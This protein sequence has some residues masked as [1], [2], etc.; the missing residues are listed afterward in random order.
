MYQN[1]INPPRSNMKELTYA[2][3]PF[4]PN[5]YIDYSPL[6]KVEVD[7]VTVEPSRHSWNNKIKIEGTLVHKGFSEMIPGIFFKSV[8]PENPF[9]IDR[10]ELSGPCTIVFFIDGGKEIVRKTDSDADNLEIAVMY[11]VMKHAYGNNSKL[12]KHL[13]GL[14]DEA[15]KRSDKRNSVK[16][17]RLAKKAQKKKKKNRK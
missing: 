17:K 4:V 6:Y 3:S 15:E 11:A 5:R 8:M 12:H 2:N 16:A 10:I 7:N 14:I 1:V 9:G 13:G